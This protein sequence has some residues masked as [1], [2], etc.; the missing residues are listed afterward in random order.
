[1][2]GAKADLGILGVA[3]LSVVLSFAAL[4]LVTFSLSARE[5][6]GALVQVGVLASYVAFAA[7]V[8]SRRPDAEVL[9]WLLLCTMLLLAESESGTLPFWLPMATAAA[10]VVLAD[11]DHS[12]AIIYPRGKGEVIDALQGSARA[13]LLGRRVGL[14]G[15]AAGA[16]LA[17]SVLGVILA[18]PLRLPGASAA[19]V[20]V[21]AAT[22]MALVALVT[23]DRWGRYSPAPS[24]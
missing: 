5:A 14:A 7:G 9:A 21:F 2:D 3:R 11:A 18:P 16:A 1:M 10:F 15:A 24:T 8:W 4:S 19:V 23:W 12:A 17:V 22:A 13:S 6:A 20:G